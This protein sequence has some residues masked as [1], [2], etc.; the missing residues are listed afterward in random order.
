MYLFLREIFDFEMN[1]R[2]LYI[3]I[4]VISALLFIPY[5][6]MVH[7]FDW[8]EI[9]FAEISREM[10]VSG[11]Y[12]RVQIEFSPFWEK[13]PLFFW[14]QAMAMQ[15][16]GVGE[17]ASRL[18]NALIGI[19]TLLVVFH[20]G[21]KL[22]NSTFGMVWV[23]A[24][25]GSFLPHFYFKSGIIDPLFNLFIFLSVSQ[26]A[27]LTSSEEKM[28]RLR[29]A[30][31]GGLFMGVAVLTKGPVALLLVGVCG[32]VYWIMSQSFRTFKILELLA[33]AILT[34]L[35]SSLWYIPEA[36]TNDF[37][38]IQE[39]IDYQIG[40]AFNSAD[41][42]HEQPFWYHPVVLLI[43]CFPASIY[44]LKSFGKNTE[45]SAI[46]ANFRWWMK[47]LFWV[48][49]IIFSIVKAKIVH[50][51][52]LCYFPLTFLATEYLYNVH[53]EKTKFAWWLNILLVFIGTLL[54]ALFIV[55]PWVGRWKEAIIPYIQDKFTVAN[56][57]ANVYWSGFESLVGLLL[58]GAVI[59]VVFIE[60]KRNPL[61]GALILFVSTII[62]LQFT[63][64]IFV[65]KIERYSQGAMIDFLKSIQNE[66][67]YIS[68]LTY[69]SYAH[70]FYGS[71][72]PAQASKKS[73]Y[74]EK[75]FGEKSLS[76]ESSSS[77]KQAW[78]D[79]LLNGNIDKPAYLLTKIDRDYYKDHPDL[80]KVLDKNGFVIYKREIPVREDKE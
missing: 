37:W 57:E 65:P 35:V 73:K 13:P 3:L 41:T 72:T 51:S 44:F 42:G 68:P 27:N 77:L 7:L 32:L 55:L 45:S 20:L 62:T 19:L 4:T 30:L 29:H 39:F 36:M 2:L 79:W 80:K 10:I 53:Q 76:K 1:T 54:S 58:L 47:L 38:F 50:Y 46:Q 59:Y 43:G 8:D 22:Y 74:L 67:C 12:A 15:V 48:T 49:L 78:N 56:L 11:N 16:F 69:H 21:K 26:L 60:N 66:D 28:K 23:L 17:F 24:Y 70:H 18:P 64:Y 9:N 31:L 52:S 34:L 61:K 33:Y 25:A 40:L 5:L 6:G 71:I 63:F 14:L 75:K